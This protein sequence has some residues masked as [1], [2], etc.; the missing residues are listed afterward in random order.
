MANVIIQWAKRAIPAGYV[1][2]QAMILLILGILE[3]NT[4]IQYLFALLATITYL[5]TAFAN[6]PIYS[7]SQAMLSMRRNNNRLDPFACHSL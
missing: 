7:F 2:L 4:S 5:W 3:T 6:V 1:F